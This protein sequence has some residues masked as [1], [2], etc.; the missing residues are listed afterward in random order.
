M[1]GLTEELTTEQ[2][3][4]LAK[5]LLEAHGY[6]VQAPTTKETPPV[7][8][9]DRRDEYYTKEQYL[10]KIDLLEKRMDLL[11][12]ATV[13]NTSTT[14]EASRAWRKKRAEILDLYDRFDD[15][16]RGYRRDLAELT[17][18]GSSDRKK[19]QR[20]LKRQ[21][22]RENKRR[23]EAEFEQ[24]VRVLH[25]RKKDAALMRECEELLGKTARASRSRELTATPAQAKTMDVLR[26]MARNVLQNKSTTPQDP[27]TSTTRD[28]TAEPP[29]KKRRLEDAPTGPATGPATGPEVDPPTAGTGELVP[30]TPSRIGGIPAQEFLREADLDS[31]GEVESDMDSTGNAEAEEEPDDWPATPPTPSYLAS[32]KQASRS[33][34][35][36]PVKEFTIPKRPVPP[37]L[38]VVVE[39]DGDDSESSLLPADL[40]ES[41]GMEEEF[42][43]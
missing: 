7:Q 36:L 43:F 25:Q 3:V 23:Q 27:T 33:P 11:M 39:E 13:H 42:V 29:K 40:Y 8:V 19:E 28:P 4:Q 31:T 10:R 30:A 17:S 32:T 34:S 14:A 35:P 22:R 9:N 24:E 18:P 26:S 12:K 16:L 15:R 21:E 1:Y 37:V 20:G 2:S 41:D 6:K 38:P 5:A